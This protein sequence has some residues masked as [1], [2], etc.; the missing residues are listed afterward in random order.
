MG[1]VLGF[2]LVL[3][4]AVHAA[5]PFVSNVRAEQR[6]GTK[7]VDI[8]YDVSDADGDRMNISVGIKDGT[9][10]VSAA[11]LSGDVG[12]NLVC[13][14]NKKIIWNAGADW[15]GNFSTLTVTVMADDGHTQAVSVPCPVAKTGQTISYGTGDDGDLQTGVA[16]PDPRFTDLGDGTVKDNL[17]G[18]EWAQAPHSL[19][20]NSTNMDWN[21]AIDFCNNLVYAGHSDWRLPSRKELMS[22]VDYGRY[23][24]ALP[25]G[26]PFAGVQDGKYCWS[27]TSRAYSAGYAWI[28]VVVNGYVVHGFKATGYYVWPV[29]GGESAGSVSPVPKTGQTTSYR[30]RDDGDLETGVAWPN[31]RFTD[32][33][34]GT[35]KDN[36]TGLEWVQAPHSLSGNST[37][38]NW[39]AAVDFCNNLVYA[40]RS[41]WRL[42]SVKEL[43]SLVNCGTYNPAL[44]AGH[45]FAGVQTNNYWSGTSFAYNTFSAWRVNM[46]DGYVHS[47]YKTDDCYVWPVRGGQ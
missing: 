38:M 8:W 33:S 45:P 24:P 12:T 19:S 41:D 27:G 32:L 16:W 18:L 13:G 10:T 2:I 26:H 17:T 47:R 29:R 36:L 44:P 22:L 34:D 31:P 23:S 46:Y 1:L 5:P 25:A 35:V 20:G 6:S 21:S 42:P 4:A 40:G 30:T 11:A 43:E 7:S 3:A 39:N 14:T 15:S 28:V 9:N 37:Y